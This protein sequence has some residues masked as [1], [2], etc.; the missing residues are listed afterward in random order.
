MKAYI[1]D[2]CD[3]ITTNQ[4]EMGKMT[5]VDFATDRV[6]KVQEYH[7]CDSCA[8]EVRKFIRN[9]ENPALKVRTNKIPTATGYSG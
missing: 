5:R 1:C 4:D 6:G 3:I 2:R 9:N 7:L 8:T